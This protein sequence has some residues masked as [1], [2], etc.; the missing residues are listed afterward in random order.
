MKKILAYLLLSATAF[1]Y[2]IGTDIN[3]EVQKDVN[4]INLSEYK[5]SNRTYVQI[6]SSSDENE[7]Q[8]LINGFIAGKEIV[9]IQYQTT[10]NERRPIGVLYTVYSVLIT[11]KD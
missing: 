4:K 3:K 11:Y 7:L 10:I 9:D 1:G 5:P 8:T 6:F 2:F